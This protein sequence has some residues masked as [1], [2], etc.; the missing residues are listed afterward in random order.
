MFLF[1][2]RGNIVNEI[3]RVGLLIISIKLVLEMLNW[4]ELVYS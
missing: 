3:G 1:I 2:K 4:K